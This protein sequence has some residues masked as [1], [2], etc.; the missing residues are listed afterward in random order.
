[1]VFPIYYYVRRINRLK[2]VIGQH[3]DIFIL[4]DKEE[5]DGTEL[6]VVKSEM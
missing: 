2:V 5:L 3:N 1:M 6:V 4:D